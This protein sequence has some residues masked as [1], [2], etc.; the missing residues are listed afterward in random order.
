MVASR[1][2]LVRPWSGL[3]SLFVRETPHTSLRGPLRGP[4]GST[5]AG[6]SNVS[7]KAAW[8]SPQPGPPFGPGGGGGAVVVVV[9]AAVVV[10]GA[11][12][13]L[14][15]VV[16]ATVVVVVVVGATVVVVVVV[17]ATVVVVVGGAVV[18][19]VGAAVVVVVGATVVVVVVGGG[20][21][22]VTS[23]VAAWSSQSS[24]PFQ[25]APKIPTFT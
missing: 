24:S 20:A 8:A 4:D 1:H 10:V 23:K 19:V 14:V 9:G 6:A 2:G 25:P 7:Q 3:T 5:L 21:G 22:F 18:V 11:T 17:G 13:V 16:G 12:V 15:V